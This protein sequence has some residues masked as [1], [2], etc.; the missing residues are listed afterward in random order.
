VTD[1]QLFGKRLKAARAA[2]GIKQGRL[3][4]G[5]DVDPKHISRLEQG[6]VKP[7]FEL[8]CRASRVLRVSPALLMDLDAEQNAS[9][10]KEHIRRLLETAEGEQLQRA[11]RVLKALL[12]P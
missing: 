11:F 8:I 9:T 2:A 3:A 1:A 10:L 5:L 4:K 7:S 12:Q 6:K